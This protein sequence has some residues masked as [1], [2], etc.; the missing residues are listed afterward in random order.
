MPPC[1]SEVLPGPAE[2]DCELDP[3]LWGR[4]SG[5]RGDIRCRGWH[6]ADYL[7]RFPAYEMDGVHIS[8][9]GS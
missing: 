1:L 8:C 6:K 5:G 2:L 4:S 9:P 7:E 3:Q